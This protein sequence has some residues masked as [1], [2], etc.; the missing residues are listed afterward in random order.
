MQ[1]SVTQLIFPNNLAPK[2][3]FQ[4]AKRAGYQAMELSLRKGG[5]P[6]LQSTDQE[7]Q[8]VVQAARAEGIDLISMTHTQLT[9]SM[10][11]TPESCKTA[12]AETIEGL[13]IAKKLGIPCTLHTLGRMNPQV[14]YEDAY[15]QAQN[16][17]RQLLPV[18]D[19]LKI[20]IALEFVWN[21]F[22]F[23]PLEYRRFIQEIG[24]D[25]IGFYFDPGNMA[26]FHTPQHWVRALAKEIKLVHLK[27]WT[28][29]ALNGKW[30]PLLA[31][32]VN[33]PDLMRE[34]KAIGYDGPL[35]SEVDQ[36][37]ADLATTAAAI[38]KIMALG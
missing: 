7:L 4:Q 10:L 28:G 37:L 2:D 16:A 31:G 5:I 12:I 24:S 22:G 13:H 17:L 18:L 32:A 14:Y 19:Q 38:R 20:D 29:G 15:L 27:D 34:L 3:M 23:S 8:E 30:T 36:S 26:V 11:G 9:G 21:G 25:R 35:T 33:F 6:S 1:V